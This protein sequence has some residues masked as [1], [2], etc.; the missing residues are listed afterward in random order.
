MATVTAFIRVSTKKT[1]KANVRFRL[2][3]GRSI[4]LLL[5]SDIEVN[6]EHWD[7]TKQELK[8]KILFD[9]AK[10]AE[11]NKSVADLKNIILTI[12][13]A[14]PIKDS[15][16]SDWLKEEVDKVL[17]PEKYDLIEK[18]KTFFETYDYFLESRSEE[19]R[20]GKEC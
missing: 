3:D 8:A 5:A 17:H 18:Q 7:S 12:Y 13:N 20:V 15:L 10:R 16:T 6:P 14:A 2:R 9:T 11:F 19:R 1:K 4:Q